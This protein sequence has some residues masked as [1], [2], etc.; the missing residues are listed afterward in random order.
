MGIK[1]KDLVCPKTVQLNRPKAR[2]L[3]EGNLLWHRSNVT[4]QN[5]IE[6]FGLK[7][8]EGKGEFISTIGTVFMTSQL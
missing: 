5:Y 4:V 6:I 1:A 7:T 8:N 3:A 2:V